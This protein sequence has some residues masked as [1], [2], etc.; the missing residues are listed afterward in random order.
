[1]EA[2]WS[3]TMNSIHEFYLVDN[4]IKRYSIGDRSPTRS[5]VNGRRRSACRRIQA[6]LQF[7]YGRSL[8]NDGNVTPFYDDRQVGKDRV[9]AMQAMIFSVAEQPTSAMNVA[10]A[11]GGSGGAQRR[12]CHF[13]VAAAAADGQANGRKGIDGCYAGCESVT[14]N[15]PKRGRS[16]VPD[17]VAG[18]TTASL[19]FPTRTRCRGSMP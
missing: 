15:P 14:A 1:M 10:L 16:L 2:F 8:G 17:M 4:V 19:V 18:M 5:R 7:A 6:R 3:L 9:A 11:N 12:S 13:D